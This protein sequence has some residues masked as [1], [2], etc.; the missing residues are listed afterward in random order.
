M[1]HDTVEIA[2]DHEHDDHADDAGKQPDDLTSC[3]IG[4]Q[5]GDER[6]ADAGKREHDG[7][8]GRISIR[9]E[10]AHGR[11]GHDEGAEQADRHGEGLGV[12]RGAV[13]HEH[14]GEEQ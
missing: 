6:D 1:L 7:Q 13:V 10:E 9:R 11:V 2:R 14:H 5:S 3:Q 4:S 12:E 8:D